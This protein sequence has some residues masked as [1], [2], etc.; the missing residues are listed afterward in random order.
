MI[1]H[2]S[3]TPRCKNVESVCA[4]WQFR[5]MANCWPGLLR[6]PPVAYDATARQMDVDGELIKCAAAAKPE[7]VFFPA[8]VLCNPYIQPAPHK[9]VVS[10]FVCEHIANVIF[11][12]KEKV[13]TN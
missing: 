1:W 6:Q 2:N 9:T 11:C 13:K 8:W 3:V 4:C 5:V 12:L 10:A 7:Q